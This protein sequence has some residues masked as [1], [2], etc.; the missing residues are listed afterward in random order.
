MARNKVNTAAKQ[1]KEL[2][3][4]DYFYSVVWSEEDEAFIG[5]VLEFPSLAAHGSTQTK[6]LSEIRSVVEH[7]IDDLVE[8]GEEAPRPLNKRPYSGKLN[9]RLPK[10]LHRHLAI[11]AA[12]EGV[13]LN[14]LISTKLA[15]TDWLNSRRSRSSRRR[16]H[17]PPQ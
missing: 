1:A 15:A 3:T 5:R 12:E 10:Y 8:S 17:G 16:E 9:V 6:A 2:D 4:R 7:A 13:S 11:E 14:Q